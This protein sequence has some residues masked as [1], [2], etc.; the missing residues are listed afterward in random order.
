MRAARVEPTSHS[1]IRM[2]RM[3]PTI[4]SHRLTTASSYYAKRSGRFVTLIFKHSYIAV[5]STTRFSRSLT[6]AL[7]LHRAR[8]AAL[9][10]KGLTAD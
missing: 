4:V 6:W 5:S 7:A 3:H 10:H 1:E 8:F 9:A 2:L